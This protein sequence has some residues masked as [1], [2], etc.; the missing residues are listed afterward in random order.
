MD[1]SEASEADRTASKK[2]SPARVE[3]EREKESEGAL[4]W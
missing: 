2:Q 3:R 4:G 1:G